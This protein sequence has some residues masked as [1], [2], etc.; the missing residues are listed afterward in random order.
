MGQVVSCCCPRDADNSGT[1]DAYGDRSRLIGNPDSGTSGLDSTENDLDASHDEG[2][3][4]NGS[5]PTGGDF[6]FGNSKGA[7]VPKAPIDE[8]QVGC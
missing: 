5:V 6:L 8:H 1:E 2:R 3:M 7:S 4:I